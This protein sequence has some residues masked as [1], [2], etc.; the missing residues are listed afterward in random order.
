MAGFHI[1]V[2]SRDPDVAP[3]TL[4]EHWLNDSTGQYWTATGTSS[5]SDWQPVGQARV[6]TANQSVPAGG[7]TVTYTHGFGTT[8]IL[9]PQFYDLDDPDGKTPVNADWDFGTDAPNEI[10]VTFSFQTMLRAVISR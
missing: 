5:V 9:E 3:D 7:G 6:Y 10:D 1:R 4:L 8:D 2:E